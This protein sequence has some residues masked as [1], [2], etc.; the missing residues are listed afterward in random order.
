M[1]NSIPD[2]SKKLFEFVRAK[3]IKNDNL[4]EAESL[5]YMLLEHVFGIDKTDIIL[6]RSITL[7]NEKGK[8]LNNFIKRI[9]QDEPVQ[10]II[11]EAFF[12]GRRFF[13]DPSVLIPRQET[14]ELIELI[15]HENPDRKLRILDIGTGTGCIPI[16]LIKEQ[17]AAKCYAL[18]ISPK[19]M[20]VARRNAERHAATI[21]F[22]LMDVLT[23]EL[24]MDQLDLVVSNPPY[25]TEEEKAQM[26]ANVLNFE[27]H[28]ALFVPNEDPLIFFNRI[29]DQAL[30]ALKPGGRLYFEI[31]ENFGE[32][33]AE[34]LRERGY[35]N[36]RVLKD[37]HGKDRFVR[38]ESPS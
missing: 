5:T 37:I 19:A 29:A 36:I 26:E 9:N 16:T 11:G 4:R 25:V 2:S 17:A 13:V 31:N 23:E 34:G 28:T 21:E 7:D 20:K 1:S 35:V 18:E 3:T 10:Y 22:I 33:V 12:Y 32:P 6:D 14:E 24:P 8:K 27:P 30:K 38:G 15:L